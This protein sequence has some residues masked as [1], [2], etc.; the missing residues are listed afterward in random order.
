MLYTLKAFSGYM[1]DGSTFTAPCT[2][3]RV[4]GGNETVGASGDGTSGRLRHG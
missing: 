4:H 3:L 1:E 2:Q